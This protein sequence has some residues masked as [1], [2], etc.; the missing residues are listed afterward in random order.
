M[1]IDQAKKTWQLAFP[2]ILGEVAQMMLGIID[3]AMVGAVNYKQLAAA[4]LVMSVINIPYVFGIGITISVSQMV[5]M[6]HGR[7][8]GKLV[9]HYL[10]NGF[11]LCAFS[12]IG[13]SLAI[14]LSRNIVFHLDQDPE[15]ARLALP[16][17]Q[18]MGWSVIPM[19]LFLALKQFTDGL[20][21]T[22]TAMMLSLA[23]LPMNAFLNWIFIYGN[24]G[25][26]RMELMGA[27]W[28]TLITRI[29]IFIV[30]GLIILNHKT[31]RRY[32]AVGRLVWKLRWKTF[33]ELLHI[34]IPS[35]FQISMEAGA[36]AV[37]GILI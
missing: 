1:L 4:A 5:S 6:A 36:F 19:I 16:Y 24:W 13:I 37:S 22:K 26:P 33:K 12:A 2:I 9:S 14:E 17:L 31:F 7:R 34:G 11:W 25:F 10:Y 21:F 30:L 8:D 32:I 18:V 28:A 23:A 27:G 15:V 29:F 3:T 20:E 35:S